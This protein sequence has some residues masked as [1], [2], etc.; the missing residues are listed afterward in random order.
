V[1]TIFVVLLTIALGIALGIGS[2]MLKIRARPWNRQADEGAGAPVLPS[3]GPTPRVSVDQTEYRFGTFSKEATGRHE[4]VFRNIG[5]A[6]L[7]LTAGP[8]SASGMQSKIEGGTVPPGGSAIVAV[9]WRSNSNSGPYQQQVKIL[10]ND[11]S[12]PEVLL[13]LAGDFTAALC[14][15]P[16]TVT[17]NHVSVGERGTVRSRLFCYL[18]EPL[19]IVGHRWADASTASYFDVTLQPLT[20]KEVK[21]EP[22]AHSGMLVEVA[23]KPGMLQGLIRQALVLET[24]V[25]SMRYIGLTMN[26]IVGSGDISVAGPGWD[27]DTGILTLGRV[28]RRE[29][30]QQRLTLIVRG[31]LAKQVEFKPEHVEPG[32]L[33]VTVGPRGS[34][35][36]DSAVPTP[37]LIDIP[38]GSA[39]ANHVGSEQGKIGEIILT[40]THP[41]V[42]RLRIF[43][44]FVIEG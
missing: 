20:E 12:Q 33:K 26:G 6:P 34:I 1:K 9:S 18:N 17:F 31:P 32:E 8:V 2:A 39:P 24:N 13:T 25:A 41:K 29:G 40:T 44:S 11:P 16:P 38:P 3:G 36:Q 19:R 21:E 14:L 4:F 43:V 15:S 28:A 27:P 10:T 35:G 7:V 42:P 22:G 30:R 5:G 37:L 23:V